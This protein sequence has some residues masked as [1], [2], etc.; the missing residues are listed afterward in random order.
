MAERKK[1]R[2][3]KE[4]TRG[5]GGGGDGGISVPEVDLRP[6]RFRST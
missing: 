2:T 3:L 5:G 1:G 4:K 6:R